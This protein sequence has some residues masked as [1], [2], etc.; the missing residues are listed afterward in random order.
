MCLPQVTKLTINKLYIIFLTLFSYS[1]DHN[2]KHIYISFYLYKL[3]NISLLNYQSTN[4]V[5][6]QCEMAGITENGRRIM[7]AI[8]EGEESIYALTWCLKNLVFQNSK[9]HLILLYVKPPRVV[10][11][12]FD[13]TGN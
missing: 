9:D 4:L 1:T 6:K 5:I 7:V 8:D 2:L 3:L 13:G 12:A 11:S 10:Y